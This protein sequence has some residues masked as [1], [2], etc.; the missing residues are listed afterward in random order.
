MPPLGAIVQSSNPP[1]VVAPDIGGITAFTI[2]SAL[3]VFEL[4]FRCFM[5]G[6]GE[7]SSKQIDLNLHPSIRPV[8]VN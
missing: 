8:I 6:D 3:S 1:F 2:G 4:R 5:D 7:L